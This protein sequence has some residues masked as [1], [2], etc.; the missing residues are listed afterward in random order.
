[1]RSIDVFD[2]RILWV[3]VKEN[4]RLAKPLSEQRP[5]RFHERTHAPAS[6]DPVF[7][8]NKVGSASQIIWGGF[9]VHLSE[10][11]GVGLRTAACITSL[12]LGPFRPV[13]KLEVQ[14]ARRYTT[15]GSIGLTSNVI[16]S[17][18]T[19]RSRSLAGSMGVARFVTD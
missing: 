3:K 6:P 7:R 12:T 17:D 2:P 11:S 4:K 14:T 19:E 9:P 18:G 15:W 10:Y 13:F 8:G 16:G 5:F 1:M